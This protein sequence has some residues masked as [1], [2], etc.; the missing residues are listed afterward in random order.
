MVGTLG[1][2]V[3]KGLPQIIFEITFKTFL[4]TILVVLNF[5]I[6]VKLSFNSYH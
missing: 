4:L 6:F 1:V 5:K 2:L 3:I